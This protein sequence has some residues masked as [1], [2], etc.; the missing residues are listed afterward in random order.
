MLEIGT[1]EHYSEEKPLPVR[2]EAVPE[3]GLSREKEQTEGRH[4]A[5][6]ASIPVVNSTSGGSVEVSMHLLLC[7]LWKHPVRLTRW[8]T[9]VHTPIRV[10]AGFL[11]QNACKGG[12]LKIRQNEEAGLGIFN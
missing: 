5:I 8:Y 1:S 12:H 9:S 3:K 6:Q 7:F 4:N 2:F 11:M 10:I